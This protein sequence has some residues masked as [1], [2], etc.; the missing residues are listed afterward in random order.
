MQQKLLDVAIQV[1]NE[2]RERVANPPYYRCPEGTNPKKYR[3]GSKLGKDGLTAEELVQQDPSRARGLLVV[4]S[5]Q[6]LL[7]LQEQACKHRLFSQGVA[8]FVVTC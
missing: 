4:E 6:L 8:C 5:V 7:A 2:T 3:A 1:A